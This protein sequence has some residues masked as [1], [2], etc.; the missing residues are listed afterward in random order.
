M[1]AVGIAPVGV[2]RPAPGRVHDRIGKMPASPAGLDSPGEAGRRR[3]QRHRDHHLLKT[4]Y[5]HLGMILMMSGRGGGRFFRRQID[6]LQELPGVGRDLDRGVRR[7]LAR[8]SPAAARSST[9]AA[10]GA[11]PWASGSA[12][13]AES[14]GSRE[15]G[16]ERQP[17]TGEV[18]VGIPVQSRQ[19][20]RPVGEFLIEPIPDCRHR[21]D[22]VRIGLAVDVMV[23]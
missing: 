21:S 19:L 23:A 22:P 11:A 6:P 9:A 7:S 20:P 18:V 10:T 14:L 15:D 12:P 16:A 4:R 13:C 8:P 17:A 5:A 3:D 2:E 1:P